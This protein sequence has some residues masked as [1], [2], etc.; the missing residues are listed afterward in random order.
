MTALASDIHSGESFIIS[1]TKTIPFEFGPKCI[2][3]ARPIPAS[4]GRTPPRRSATRS[5]Q[6]CPA[7]ALRFAVD[8]NT[9]EP[10]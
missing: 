8:F 1:E 2:R 7:D 5:F 9:Y 3:G 10:T 6:F 4:K